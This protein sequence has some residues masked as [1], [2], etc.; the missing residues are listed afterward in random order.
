MAYRAKNGK[1]YPYKETPS[2]YSERND[3]HKTSHPAAN[4]V[5]ADLAILWFL[6]PGI[7]V[8]GF[9]YMIFGNW[10]WLLFILCIIGI[11]V[12]VQKVPNN[13]VD[14]KIIIMLL[15]SFFAFWLVKFALQLLLALFPFLITG[16][17]IWGIIYFWNKK[18][19]PEKTDE[20]DS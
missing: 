13:G 19:T 6:L 10:I 17:I 16:G 8:W 9:M 4:Q 3:Q 15:G 7:I 11:G 1:V 14:E 5:A 18:K 2:Q 20:L 12:G